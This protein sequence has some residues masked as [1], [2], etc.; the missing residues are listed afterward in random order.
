MNEEVAI[1]RR[2]ADEVLPRRR[3]RWFSRLAKWAIGILLALALAAAALMV[4]LDTDAG[5]RFLA[6]R[7]AALSPSSGLKIRIGR[8]EGSI[9]NETRLRDVRVY[10]PRGLFAESPRIDVRWRPVQWLANRLIIDDLGSDLV[11][12]HRLPKLIP[13]DRPRPILPGF[14]VRVGRLRIA[15]LRLERGVAGQ[16]RIAAVTG[17]ADI[18]SGRALV[19]LKADVRGGGDKLALLLDAEP[20]RDRFD[21]DVRLDS[22]ANGV[23]ANLLG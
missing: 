5:H 18:R 15:E 17:E 12:L 16:R 11:T 20:D 4:F 23:A 10:D 13:S 14:D 2:Q 21:V 8:I 1:E 7:V 22:P 19:K 9:W 6:D 3:R